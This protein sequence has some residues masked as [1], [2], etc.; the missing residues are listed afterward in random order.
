MAT[1][2]SSQSGRSEGGA[3]LGQGGDGISAFHS[4][5]HLSSRPGRTRRS[6]AASR[7]PAT[8]LHLGRCGTRSPRWWRRS[9]CE[10]PRSCPPAVTSYQAGHV[11]GRPTAEPDLVGRPHVEAALDAL[12]VGVLGRGE[13]AAGLGQVAQ[14]V[15]DGLL[16]HLAVAV[17][18]R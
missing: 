12:G 7:A 14:H 10:R 1:A 18:A 4:V 3:G 13:A 11:V 8:G 9:G 6:R 16:H 15:G 5:R 17:V 2:A